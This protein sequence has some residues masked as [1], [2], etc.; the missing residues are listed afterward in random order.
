MPTAICRS[1]MPTA[2]GALALAG[3]R[4]VS[5][6]ALPAVPR[7][8]RGC[9]T[10]VTRRAAASCRAGIWRAGRRPPVLRRVI[11][12]ATSKPMA[13]QTRL[14]VVAREA[15]PQSEL[16][17]GHLSAHRNSPDYPALLVM[18]AVLGGQ[19][20]SRINLKLREE[21]G[22]TYGA[23]TGFDWRR[24]IAPFSLQASV[25]T[26]AT[27]DAIAD[28]FAEL[29]AIRGTRPPT[30][31]RNGARQGVAHARVSARVRDGSPGR[32][33]GRAARAVSDCRI[34]TSKSLSR[35]SARSRH[36]DVVRV[37]RALPRS[38]PHRHAGRRRLSGG[39]TLARAARSGR[40]A[41]ACRRRVRQAGPLR[42]T[43][44]TDSCRRNLVST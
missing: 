9:R 13:S 19:F 1:A 33:G 15:A 35:V 37:G 14:A 25:H 36:G 6:G 8:G 20:V 21:K 22:Y 7:D 42:G 12:P 43:R 11:P 44:P 2:L 38:R 10:A 17:I 18:N 41:D 31:R 16:R 23:R 32:A 28:C 39:R 34:R 26:A 5:S 29:D 4:C 24:G 27:A 3:R 40:T 30:E